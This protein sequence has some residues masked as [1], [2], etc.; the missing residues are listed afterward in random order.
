ML[1]KQG[2]NTDF[3]LNFSLAELNSWV[4]SALFLATG[5][6]PLDSSSL[7]RVASK[8]SDALKRLAEKL[9]NKQRDNESDA[10]I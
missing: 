2:L 8:N 6:R 4:G 7:S 10:D 3:V 1:G 5:K 9:K